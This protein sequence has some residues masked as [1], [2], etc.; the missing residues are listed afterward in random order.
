MNKYIA[1]G[2]GAIIFF[3]FLYYWSMSE[4]KR[5]LTTEQKNKVAE[6]PT[7]NWVSF[8]VPGKLLNAGNV[9]NKAGGKLSAGATMGGK[10]AK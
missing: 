7:S 8:M 10:A 9:A 2:L 3:G 1:T 6:D 5:T 4:F